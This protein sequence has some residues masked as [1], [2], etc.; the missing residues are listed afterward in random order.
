MLLKRNRRAMSQSS[1]QPS[2]NK[3]KD[4]RNKIKQLLEYQRYAV[5]RAASMGMS[6]QE[7]TE[8]EA[9]IIQIEELLDSIDLN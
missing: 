9:R 2:P 1:E 3:S 4:A 7:A 6:H 5:H 8:M